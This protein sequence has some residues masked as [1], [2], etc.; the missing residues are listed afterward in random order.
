MIAAAAVDL[1]AA[2]A[3][4]AAT[5]AGATKINNNIKK[6]PRSAWGF[7]YLKYLIACR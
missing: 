2:V 6:S 1:T 3:A 5:I 7:F 4:A